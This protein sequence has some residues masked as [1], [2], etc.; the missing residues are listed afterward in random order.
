MKIL[1]ELPTAI[2]HFSWHRLADLGEEGH[3]GRQ[4]DDQPLCFFEMATL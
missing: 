4:N 2:I 3:C 1:S